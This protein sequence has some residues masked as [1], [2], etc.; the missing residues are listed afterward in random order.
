MSSPSAEEEAV[1]IA[2]E[3][4]CLRATA[5]EEQLIFM[6]EVCAVTST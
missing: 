1:V 4:D 2:T 6:F 5:V 3:A